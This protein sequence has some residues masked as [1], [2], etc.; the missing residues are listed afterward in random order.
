MSG[1]HEGKTWPEREPDSDFTN[2][3]KSSEQVPTGEIK[4]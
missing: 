3:G 1:K 4:Q 2:S